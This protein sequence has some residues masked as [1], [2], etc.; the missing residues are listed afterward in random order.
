MKILGLKSPGLERSLMRELDSLRMKILGAEF[1]PSEVST[2]TGYDGA[3][4]AKI[5]ASIRA[6]N[7]E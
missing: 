7:P 1:K 4:I 3:R 5:I 2:A 6:A